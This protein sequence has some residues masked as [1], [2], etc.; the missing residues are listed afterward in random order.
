MLCFSF[1]AWLLGEVDSAICGL[2]KPHNFSA[3]PNSPWQISYR[4]ILCGHLSTM[5]GWFF[6]NDVE[7]GLYI[8]NAVLSLYYSIKSYKINITLIQSHLTCF[9][10]PTSLMIGHTYVRHLNSKT[11]HS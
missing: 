10:R 1:S 2:R 4:A 9:A 7:T 8:K 5:V 3:C 6:S 11:G